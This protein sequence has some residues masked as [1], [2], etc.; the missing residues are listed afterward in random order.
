MLNLIILILILIGL[1]IHRYL[2]SF[3]EQGTL[4]YGRGFLVFSNIF[5]VIYLVNYIWVFGFVIGIIIAAL[6]FFQIVYIS[7]LWP[8]LLPRLISIHKQQPSSELISELTDVNPIAYGLWS[9]LI[10]VL[11]ILAIVNFFISDYA[12][13]TK[14]IVEF[15]GGTYTTPLFW[16]VGIAIVSNIVRIFVSSRFL[17]KDGLKKKP[18]D[19]RRF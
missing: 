17:K 12:S 1:V 13:M 6:T 15:F 14:R 3:W 9:F 2:S 11:G 10:V 8:F 16:V 7:F 18:W 19:F 4:P 5:A